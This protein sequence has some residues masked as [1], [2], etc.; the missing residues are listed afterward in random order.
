MKK[1]TAFALLFIMLMTVLTFIPSN[2]KTLSETVNLMQASKNERGEGYYWHNPSHT[3]TL[4]NLSIDTADKYGIRVP[5]DATVILEGNNVIKASEIAFYC[6]GTVTVKGN[7]KL[8]LIADTGMWNNSSQTSDKL[9]ILDTTVIIEAAKT[10]VLSGN[11]NFSVAGGT[12]SITAGECAVD[13]RVC[14][15][16]SGLTLKTNNTVRGSYKL[17]LIAVNADIN[18]A[19]GAALESDNDIILNK[20]TSESYNIGEKSLVASSTV[21]NEAKSVLFGENFPAILDWIVVI[22]VLAVVA[23]VIVVPIVLQKK[24]DQKLIMANKAAA[25]ERIKAKK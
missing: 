6:A 5:N 12:M 23:A 11:A 15:F 2:A 25:K 13:G 4:T 18:S 7:G 10:G 14:S 3:L 17:E 8:T 20:M 19:S 16:I 22:C 21:S 1:K 24:R 9:R